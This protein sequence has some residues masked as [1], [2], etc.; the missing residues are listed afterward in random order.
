VNAACLLSS[1]ELEESTFAPIWPPLILNNPVIVSV[2]GT[3]SDDHNSVIQVIFS[4]ATSFWVVN[5]TSIELQEAC[6]D[7]SG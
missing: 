5:T 6:V 4:I 3:V 1:G 2:F 7:A